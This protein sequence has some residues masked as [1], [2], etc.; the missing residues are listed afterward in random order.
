[1]VK[2]VRLIVERSV[3]DA[4]SRQNCSTEYI[5]VVLTIIETADR[6]KASADG[7]SC[8]RSHKDNIGMSFCSDWGH[9]GSG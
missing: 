2:L 1:M 4:V 5:Y 3:A 7:R 9:N 6:S 8:A